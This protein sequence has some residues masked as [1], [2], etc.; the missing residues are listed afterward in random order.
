MK[1]INIPFALAVLAMVTGFFSCKRD[2]ALKD[3]AVPASA[4]SAHVSFIDVAVNLNTVL[5]AKADTFNILINGIKVTG[6]TA[7]TS[8][9]MTMGSIYPLAGTSYGY[10]EVPTGDQTIKFARGV[11]TLDSVLFYSFN[12]TFQ[13]NTYYTLL[14]T[15]SIKSSN[16]Q[17]R[18]V[19][20]D[21][22]TLTDSTAYN[23]RFINTVLNDTASVDVYSARQA[24]T[25]FA[26]VKPGAVVDFGQFRS[27][28]VSDTLYCR[29]AGT[30]TNLDVLNTQQLNGYRTYTL[31]YEGDAKNAT[32]KDPKRHHLV[33]YLNR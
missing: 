18:M 3:P 20:K 8:P 16:D 22:F 25:I 4:N 26:G 12:E 24:K 2:I 1:K 9:V 27:S 31:I 17:L 28:F 32:A 6:Y 19:L 30:T 21:N 15:D 10:A 11:N 5:G 23:M 14:V 33:A 7:G 13:A 29:R